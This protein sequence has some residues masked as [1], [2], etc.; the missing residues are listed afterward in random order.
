[1]LSPKDN[2]GKD[3]ANPSR[4][5]DNSLKKFLSENLTTTDYP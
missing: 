2:K 5:L 4:K 1:M 3:A